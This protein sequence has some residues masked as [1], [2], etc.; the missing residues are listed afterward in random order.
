[1][2]LKLK[3]LVFNF[4]IISYFILFVQHCALYYVH[5]IND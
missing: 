5:I 1:M 2:E 4:K 3:F